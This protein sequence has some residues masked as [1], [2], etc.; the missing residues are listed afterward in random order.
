MVA[1]DED[2][3]EGVCTC[4]CVRVHVSVRVCVC[5]CVWLPV[6]E[7]VS[8]VC[9]RHLSVVGEVLLGKVAE[10]MGRVYVCVTIPLSWGLG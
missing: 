1:G 2:E 6:Y 10:G 4:V 5:V 7:C 9:Q 3:E 8:Y